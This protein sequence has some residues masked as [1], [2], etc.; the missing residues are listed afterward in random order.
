[1]LMMDDSSHCGLTRAPPLPLACPAVLTSSPSSMVDTCRASIILDRPASRPRPLVPLDL[2]EGELLPPSKAAGLEMASAWGEKTDAPSTAELMTVVN[3]CWLLV[4]C[5]SPAPFRPRVDTEGHLMFSSPTT[6][7]SS[8]L[9]EG[10]DDDAMVNTCS[11]GREGYSPPAVLM[12]NP[13]FAALAAEAA[14]AS[15]ALSESKF[16]PFVAL[17]LLL[18]PLRALAAHPSLLNSPLRPPL[19]LFFF[20]FFAEDALSLSLAAAGISS[21]AR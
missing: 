14:A 1:M 11:S 21:A 10:D 20:P 5:C 17:L 16:L 6:Y 12:V 18:P 19:P 4:S 3:S 9:P 15:C 7:C 2:L 8:L 13:F